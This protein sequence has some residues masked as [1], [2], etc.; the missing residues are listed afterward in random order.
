MKIQ[1]IPVLWVLT[2]LG[3]GF[4]PLDIRQAGLYGDAAWVI[5][6]SHARCKPKPLPPPPPSSKPLELD[7]DFE[8]T[9]VGSHPALATTG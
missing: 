4:Q 6:A 9:A 7:D 5:E 1:R 2:C 3:L 8:R